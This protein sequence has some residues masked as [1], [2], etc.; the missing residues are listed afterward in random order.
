VSGTGQA[1]QVRHDGTTEYTIPGMLHSPEGQMNFGPDREGIDINYPE[2]EV[3]YDSAG[4]GAYLWHTVTESVAQ[5][6]V[7]ITNLNRSADTA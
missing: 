7:S 3:S 4:F 1:P 2:F 5:G 6:M